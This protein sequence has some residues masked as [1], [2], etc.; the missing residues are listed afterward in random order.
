MPDFKYTAID[1]GGKEVTGTLPG[2]DL[3]DAAGKVRALGYYPVSVAPS[4]GAGALSGRRVVPI[5]GGKTRP[6]IDSAG[7]SADSIAPSGKKVNRVSILLFTRELADLI[8]AGLPIDRA[9]TVLIEQSDNGPLVSMIQRIQGDVRAGKPLSEALRSFPRE[10]PPLYA[11]MIHAGEVSGQLAD[12]MTRLADF[13]EKEQVRRSQ[14]IAALTYPM[15]L[16]G[17]AVLAVTFL[18][19]FV[20]PRLQG[21]FEELGT[22]LPLPTQILLATSGFMG[23]YWW[24]IL[25]GIAAGFYGFRAWVATNAGRRTWDSFKLGAPLFG[26]LTHKVVMARY[27]RTLGTLLGG[28]VPILDSMEISSTAVGNA[29]TGDHVIDARD[30]VRQ[31]ETLSSSMSKTGGFLPLV[32]HMSAVGEETGRLPNMLVRTADTLDFEVDNTMRR[33]TSRVEPLVVLFMGGFV[34]FVVL[35]IL[36]PIFEANTVVK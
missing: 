19:W 12:V 25:I 17:V 34:G 9:L 32:V 22:G 7:S 31:G 16:I 13:L 2:K 27:V 5:S 10:F 14:I 33:L 26:G 8:D 28:G 30:R 35:S 24:A 29:V 20:I 3:G 21:V 6:I 1:R 23:K 15:V 11:N 36:L 18:L 4:N